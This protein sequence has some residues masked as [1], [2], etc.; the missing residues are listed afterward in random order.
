MRSTLYN[1]V[2][3]E[4]H[5]NVTSHHLLPLRDKQESLQDTLACVR[6]LW[7]TLEVIRSA[8]EV[9]TITPP[10]AEDL[11]RALIAIGPFLTE[12]AQR[13]WAEVWEAMRVRKA[14]ADTTPPKSAREGKEG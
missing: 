14:P 9:G 13:E 11:L 8:E 10:Y 4:E 7:E 5:Q 2:L 12:E 6:C 3:P 1:Y